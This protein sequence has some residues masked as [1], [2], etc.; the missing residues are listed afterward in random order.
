[1]K[2]YENILILSKAI[3]NSVNIAFTNYTTD[4]SRF[5]RKMSGEHAQRTIVR[6]HMRIPKSDAPNI[7]VSKVYV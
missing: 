6:E 3:F 7:E 1:M 2:K 5:G 4:T